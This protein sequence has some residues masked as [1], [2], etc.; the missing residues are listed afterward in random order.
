MR[1]LGGKIKNNTIWINTWMILFMII[2]GEIVFNK[3]SWHDDIND[4]RGSVWGISNGRFTFWIITDVL[5]KIAGLESAPV[6]IGLITAVCTVFVGYMIC[7]IFEI[8]GS[9]NTNAIMLICVSIPAMAG[10]F[11]YMGGAYIDLFGEL[12]ATIAAFYAI[13]YSDVKSAVISIVVLA[14]A[15]GEYQCN[16]TMFLALLMC[17]AINEIVIGELSSKHLFKDFIRF[18]LISVGGLVLYFLLLLLSVFLTKIKL[19]SYAG[20]DAYGMTSISG[21]LERIIIAY[22]DFISPQTMRYCMFPFQWRGW[23]LIVLV[24]LGLGILLNG[25]YLIHLKQKVVLAYYLLIAF[26]IPL[27]MNFNFIMYDDDWVHSLHQ[28]NYVCL[29]LL[30]IIL[31]DSGIHNS[32]VFINSSRVHVYIKR[33]GMVTAIYIILIGIL[34][35]RYDNVCY[36][37]A[38]MRQQQ[39]ISYFT[40]VISDIHNTEGYRYDIP[41]C[42]LNEKYRFVDT[43]HGIAEYDPIMTNPFGYNIG[44]TYSWDV[45]MYE[46]CNYRPETVIEPE[47]LPDK[48]KEEVEQLPRYPN[49]GSIKVIDD[50]LV[51]N[52]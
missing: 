41:V 48:I 15:I 38:E 11:G 4:V 19:S 52:F 49:N 35:V 47:D 29:F 10:H 1:E 50:I 8:K 40:T 34:Y 7:E 16:L 44:M 37:D 28:Y 26:C 45:F 5:A 22:A 42:F 6:F 30:I 32:Q 20:V 9:I 31:V 36:L 24:L 25:I 33:L 3:L 27:I 12:L 23:H 21:Y 14:F 18:A 39:A 43:N 13:K 46:W 51:V 2:H 17:G